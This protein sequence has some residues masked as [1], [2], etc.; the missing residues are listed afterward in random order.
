[1]RLPRRFTAPAW[2]ASIVLLPFGAAHAA[3]C[4]ESCTNNTFDGTTCT[5]LATRT[6]DHS[7]SCAPNPGSVITH[8]AYDL[9][10]GSAN[11]SA[12]SCYFAPV[13]G[14]S[15]VTVRDRFRLVG[16]AGP[17][18]IS[19]QARLLTTG[20]ADGFGT[21]SAGFFESGGGAQSVNDAGQGGFA[22]M[23]VL[24][25]SLAV[26]DEVELTYTLDVSAQNAGSAQAQ[27]SF[28]GLPPGYGVSSCQGYAG[29]GAVPTRRVSWGKVKSHYR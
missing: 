5:T 23:L 19:F 25:L 14:F 28:A 12:Q 26:G 18:M 4:P 2:I 3:P 15:G 11:V 27:L 24:P 7:S 20:Q 10:A 13:N 22:T 29:E 21:V 9:V 17:G 1:M 8:E 6:V 16:P